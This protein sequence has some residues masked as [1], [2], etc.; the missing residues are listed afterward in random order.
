MAYYRLDPLPVENPISASEKQAIE[1]FFN[2]PVLAQSATF[3]LST[4]GLFPSYYL[5]HT[6]FGC[7]APERAY[8]INYIIEANRIKFGIEGKTKDA[9]KG[10]DVGLFE[11]TLL[12]TLSELKLLCEHAKVSATEQQ[13]RL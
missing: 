8:G 7:V 10:T 9:G 1:D 11:K 5:T 6:G 13:S 3:Q 12:R 2:D 4:S